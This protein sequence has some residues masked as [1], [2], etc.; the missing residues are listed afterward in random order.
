[1]KNQWIYWSSVSMS[2]MLISFFYFAY[3]Q[4]WIIFYLPKRKVDTVLPQHDRQITK[5]RVSRFYWNNDAW[6]SEEAELLWSEDKADTLAHLITSWLALLDEEK[7]MEKKVS[8]QSVVLSPS[9][10]D[11]Y[12]SFDRNPFTKNQATY[13]KFMWVEGLLKTIRENGIKVQHIHLLVHHQSL[14]DFHL[15]FSNPWPITGFLEGLK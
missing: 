9:S 11:A 12:I 10:V 6:H 15:D 2:M 1:M 3:N 4:Q 14:T 13:A 7:I 8:L 5:K